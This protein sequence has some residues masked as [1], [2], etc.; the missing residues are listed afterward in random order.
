MTLAYVYKWT[1]IPTGKWYIGSRTK[2]GSHPDDGYCCSSKEVKPLIK[3]NQIEWQREILA[4]GEPSVMLAIETT[5]LTTLDAKNDP[6]S[7]NRH[8][9][10][11]KFTTLGRIEPDNI[12]QKRIEKLKGAKRSVVALENLRVS[13]RKK[14]NDPEVVK[15]L[16]MPKP[17][18]FGEKISMALRGVEK[19]PSHRAALSAARKGVPTGRCSDVRRQAISLAQ[20]GKP[21]NN[22]L[23]ECPHCGKIGHSGAMTRWHFNNCKRKSDDI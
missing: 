17:P 13:N 16:R 19:T 6:M 15:K 3:A 20:Q 23:V 14:A 10:D 9:G 1:H 2:S 21:C 4:T 12:K 11:G 7:F 5:Y 22:P 18:G 8:N